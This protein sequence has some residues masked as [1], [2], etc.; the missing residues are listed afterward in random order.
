MAKA[1]TNDFLKRFRIESGRGFRLKDFD[2][3]DTHGFKSK[4]KAEDRL[5]H[6]IERLSELQQKLYAQDRWALLVVLQALDAAGKDGTVK[7]VMSGVNPEGCDVASFKTPTPEELDHDYLWRTTLRLPERGRIGIF[8]RSYYEDVLILRV[9]PELIETNKLPPSLVS[10]KIWKERYEDINAYERHLA[11]NGTV[12]LKFFLHLSREEQLRRFLDRLDSPDK[13]W[14]FS[15]ADVRE[16][17]YW[18]KYQKA[19]EEAIR[20]TASR[21]APWYVVPA[22]HK[23]F[24]RLVVAAAIV[25]QL[26]ALHLA[27]PVVDKDKRRELAA[28]KET[29]LGESDRGAK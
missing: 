17:A 3:A 2:P 23:W 16:R 1:K 13:N 7:H 24:S 9:H 15:L 26:E 25:E 12:I 4:K 6:D 29:L 22:D 19:Y 18:K 28:A 21:R 14:K 8:N 10:G 5:A 27:Y 11:R 20:T